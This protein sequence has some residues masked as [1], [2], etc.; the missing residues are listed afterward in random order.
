M[1][2][3]RSSFATSFGSVPTSRPH[4]KR[5]SCP[6]L[7]SVAASA[8]AGS[9]GPVH[10]QLAKRWRIFTRASSLDRLVADH[11]LPS[12][13][14]HHA[15][16]PVLPRRGERR[17]VARV[18]AEEAQTVGERDADGDARG[19]LREVLHAATLVHFAVE[20]HAVVVG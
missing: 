4:A 5:T 20:L 9:A 2:R 16:E 10:F 3:A 15:A 17:V 18:L 19:Q 1:P 6:R 13:R 12:A 11:D 14:V 7:A 8:T